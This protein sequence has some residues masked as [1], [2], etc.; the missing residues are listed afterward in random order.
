VRSAVREA[1]REAGCSERGADDV[2]L[3]VDEACQNIIRHA[4][5]GPCE[6]EIVLEMERRDGDLVLHLLD[7]APCIDEEKVRPRDLEELRPGGLGTHF[8]REL[9]DE[10]SY[11][12]PPSGRGNLLRMARRIDRSEP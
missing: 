12:R 10:V 7:F 6:S 8:I 11:E 5:G 9:M 2:V 4:Y 3:A 1:A